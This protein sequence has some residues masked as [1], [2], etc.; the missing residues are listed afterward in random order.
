MLDPLFINFPDIIALKFVCRKWGQCE[1]G[2][3]LTDIAARNGEK[4]HKESSEGQKCYITKVIDLERQLLGNQSAEF[5]PICIFVHQSACL[6]AVGIINT[7]SEE[8]GENCIKSVQ[9]DMRPVWIDL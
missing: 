7:G 9:V 6:M 4:S 3:C 5:N 2:L 1:P 8:G